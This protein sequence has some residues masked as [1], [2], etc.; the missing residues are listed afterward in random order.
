MQAWLQST[1]VAVM[2]SALTAVVTAASRQEQWR[3]LA[4]TAKGERAAVDNNEV[5][6][7]GCQLLRQAWQ[8]ALP[9]VPL[10]LQH[11]LRRRK[12]SAAVP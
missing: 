7:A 1:T 12:G 11:G 8:S 9:L 10:R 3:R 5:D 4:A 2:V 6:G